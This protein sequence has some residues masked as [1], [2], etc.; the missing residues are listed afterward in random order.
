MRQEQLAVPT[1]VVLAIAILWSLGTY[2]L[3]VSGL[4]FGG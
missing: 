2:V 4:G 1:L 3:G